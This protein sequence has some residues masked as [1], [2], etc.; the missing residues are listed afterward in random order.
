MARIIDRLAEIMA[1]R[2][3][4]GSSS[5]R[6]VKAPLPD[7]RNI[8][9]TNEL[10]WQQARKR[11]E[12]GPR[13]L[14]ATAVGGHP[15]FTVVESLIAVALTLRGAEVDILLC[16]QALP[17]CLRAKISSITPQAL[18]RE[19]LA[20]TFCAHCIATGQSVFADTGLRIVGISP[21]LQSSEIAQANDA[22]ASLPLRKVKDFRTS[23]L[24]IGE[25]GLAGALRYY[26]R[27][28]IS[29]EPYGTQVARRY[30]EAALLTA[31]A[32]QRLVH[33]R[34]YDCS[35]INHGI[36]V[37]HGIVAAA[38]RD[39]GV[40]VAAWNLAYRKQ[41]VIFSH[42]DTY[43]HTLMDEPTS[44]WEDMDWSGEHERAIVRYLESRSC[45]ARDW[46][47]FNNNPDNDIERFA[48]SAGLDWKKPVIGMLTNVV[49]DAQL[50]YPA[51]A[52]PNMVDWVIQT[53]AYFRDRPDLQLLIRVHPGEM[54]PP[55]GQ[56]KSNQPVAE[57][58]RQAFPSLPA[59]VFVIGPES[60]ISTYACAERCN[61]L[62]I[63]GT[64]AGVEFTSRGIPVIVAGEAW[65]RNKGLT[66][67][68]T[69]PEAY[70]AILDALPL[71]ERMDNVAIARARRYAYHFFFR[72]MIPLPMLSPLERAWPPFELKVDRL[73]ALLPGRSAGL[74]VVCD[75]ILRGTP[76]VYP[77]E[78]LGV[79]D[80]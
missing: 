2:P 75:G 53:V 62:I 4:Q 21:Q 41:C 7:W 69:S 13:I 19:G 65:I 74:D 32:T 14:I 3:G 24:P 15:Q 50:H 9:S 12:K 57:I 17:A 77:A 72:R 47:W 70:R 38:C 73:D 45:G 29:D 59:N 34:K 35:V 67:D 46:I 56:T 80:Q 76:F 43:H 22:A 78:R 63:Y 20:R 52:F 27:G 64:K 18:G 71:G 49:W 60:R 25:H 23:T 51:N 1:R 37:P 66:R 55:G 8:I 48:A 39:L 44:A 61:A 5:T 30:V 36:Y 28:D 40:R 68:A 58:I 42:G 79:H 10:L 33:E 11:S 16:D 31:M 26:G 54:A 6:L